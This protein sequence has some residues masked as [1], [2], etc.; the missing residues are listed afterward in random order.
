M[1]RTTEK[2]LKDC[3]GYQVWKIVDD[4][5]CR[6][7]KITYMLNDHDGNNIN[8][9]ATLAALKRYARAHMGAR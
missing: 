9:F 7:E 3:N 2:R 4:K 8:C 1:G 5:G 6:D